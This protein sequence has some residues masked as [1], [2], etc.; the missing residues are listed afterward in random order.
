MTGYAGAFATALIALD[1]RLRATAHSP[2]VQASGGMHAFGDGLL[3]L[4]VFGLVALL[5]TALA[6]YYLRPARKFWSALSLGA[7]AV[8]STGLAA[9]LVVLLSKQ[10]QLQAMLTLP[11]IFGVMRLLL[12]PVLGPTFIVCALFAPEARSRWQLGIAAVIECMA[13]ASWIVS[14]VLSRLH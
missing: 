7:L 8:A 10:P 5:P 11:A 2:D 9:A 4:F 14:I 12:A 3:F 1:Q 13:G 6:L